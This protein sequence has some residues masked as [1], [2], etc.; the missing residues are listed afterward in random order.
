MNTGGVDR[1]PVNTGGVDR[2]PVNTAREH[3]WCVWT[4]TVVVG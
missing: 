1:T 2:T 3:G 4:L